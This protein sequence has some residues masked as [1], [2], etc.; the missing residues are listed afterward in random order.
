[1]PL[2]KKNPCLNM[3]FYCAVSIIYSWLT[4]T[5][6]RTFQVYLKIHIEVGFHCFCEL[7]YHQLTSLILFYYLIE[8]LVSFRIKNEI[9]S[10]W[11]RVSWF[12]YVLH[13]CSR[14][15]ASENQ[16]LEANFEETIWAFEKGCQSLLNRYTTASEAVA[17]K[18]IGSLINS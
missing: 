11:L 12:I 15:M 18:Y 9:P 5:P 6:L 2:Q 13:T 4:I 17:S 10:P 14:G 1:M 8:N 16:N 3:L 7:R